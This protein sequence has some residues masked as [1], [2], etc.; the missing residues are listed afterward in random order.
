VLDAITTPL[1]QEVQGSS[2][3]VSAGESE[4]GS[5]ITA[6]GRAVDVLAHLLK[7]HVA[8]VPE[9]VCANACILLGQVGREGGVGAERIPELIKLKAEVRPLLVSASEADKVSRLKT[10]AAGALQRWG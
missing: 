6:P 7:G 9:E 8:N 10:A 5:P 2:A 1:P 4:I 3:P